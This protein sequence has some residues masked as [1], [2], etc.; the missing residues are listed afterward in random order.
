MIP[1][2][3][4]ISGVARRAWAKENWTDLASFIRAYLDALSWLYDRHN[5]AAAYAIL[6][7]RVPNMTA[8]LAAETCEVLLAE[9]GGFDRAARLDIDGIKTVLELRSEYPKDPRLKSSIDLAIFACRR[10]QGNGVFIANIV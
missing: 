1:R 6:V 5:R 7:T 2:Y 9:T 10:Q 3:Q 4:G 8:E